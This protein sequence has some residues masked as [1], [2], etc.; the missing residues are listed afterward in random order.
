MPNNSISIILI[1][2]DLFFIEGCSKSISIK[3]KTRIKNTE[4]KEKVRKLNGILFYLGTEA[5]HED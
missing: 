3:Q 4:K 1:S 5:E 2:F